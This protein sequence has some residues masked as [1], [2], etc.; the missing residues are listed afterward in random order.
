MERHHRTIERRFE[1]AAGAE[2]RLEIESRNG[3]V[4]VQGHDGSEVRVVA[5]VEAHTESMEEAERDFRS[6]EEGMRVDGARVRIVAP[7]SERSS[8]L[9]FGRG[10]KV[11]YEVHAPRH[12]SV[13]IE[14]RN[15]RVVVHDLAAPVKIDSRNGSIQAERIAGAVEAEGRNG[16]IDATDCGS[17]VKV[18]S[19]NGSVHV[20]RAGGIAMAETHNGDVVGQDTVHGARFRTG[21]GTIRYLGG[22]FGNLDLEV[23]GNGSI[24]MLIPPDSRFILDAE[25]VRGDVKSELPVRESTESNEPRPAVR[26][27]TING[28]IKIEALVGDA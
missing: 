13:R 5:T 18:V 2:T 20:T 14:A 17:D 22:V 26:L 27:R 28:S 16:R 19:R 25:A 7:T 6:V 8:F 11:D 24:R 21:N 3:S 10:L 4:E 15:G 9:F 1:M 23:E 12:T